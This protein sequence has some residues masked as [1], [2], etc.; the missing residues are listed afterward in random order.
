MS[1]DKRST[2]HEEGCKYD[3]IVKTQ[4]RGT[5]GNR[6]VSTNPSNKSPLTY[7][8]PSYERLTLSPLLT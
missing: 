5:K 7:V 3:F 4:G 2:S 6:G 1:S 8:E